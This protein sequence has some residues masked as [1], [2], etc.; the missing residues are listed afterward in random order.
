M[1]RSLRV[2]EINGEFPDL[3]D[4]KMSSWFKEC[5]SGRFAESGLLSHI[6]VL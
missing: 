3:W 2:F 4:I 6:I 5:P 1:K